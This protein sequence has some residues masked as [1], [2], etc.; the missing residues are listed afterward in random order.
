MEGLL[1]AYIVYFL[2]FIIP[3]TVLY[4]LC[5]RNIFL[6]ENEFRTLISII[7]S[8]ISAFICLIFMFY[9]NWK[10]LYFEI[11]VIIIALTIYIFRRVKKQKQ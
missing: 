1:F 5:I 11:L 2:I 9:Q 10:P 6:Y 7:I 8:F 4:Y 3:I